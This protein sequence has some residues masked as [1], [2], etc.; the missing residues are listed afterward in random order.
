LECEERVSWLEG[1]ENDGML[2]YLKGRTG[3]K[4]LRCVTKEEEL[5]LGSIFY[6]TAI[7]EE[8]KLE[9][10]KSYFDDKSQFV[11]TL[12]R[13]LYGDG[14]YWLEI[15]PHNATK[16]MG[17]KRLKEITGC[18]RV[19]CFGD[20]IND[21]SMFT[22][23]D[24]AYAVADANLQLKQISTGIIGSNNDDGVALWLLE[25]VNALS[26]ERKTARQI[27]QVASDV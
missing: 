22:I 24:E 17:V 10:L 12:Q 16:A 18:D 19:I 23:A 7:G 4:R 8:N 20:A 21:I 25:H 13:E 14:E 15:M 27:A 26:V 2:N 11:C 5:Y 6:F 3:E 9:K 1:K